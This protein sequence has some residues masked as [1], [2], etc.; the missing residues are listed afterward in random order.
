MKQLPGVLLIAG[1]V[2]LL[3]GPSLVSWILPPTALWTDQDAQALNQA[4]ADYHAAM[5][6]HAGP[7]HAGPDHAGDHS[8]AG[9][10]H[11]AAGTASSSAAS[12]DEAYKAQQARRD[13]SIARHGW[14]RIAVR[15]LGVLLIGAGFVF[16]VLGRQTA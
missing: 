3:L 6:N 9:H 16:Y 2:A 10:D 14:L 5:H 8:H 1:L 7:D 11:S 13:A 12:A 15:V 4:S